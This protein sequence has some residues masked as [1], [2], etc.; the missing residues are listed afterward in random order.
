MKFQKQEKFQ[1]LQELMTYQDLERRHVDGFDARDPQNSWRKS[2]FRKSGEW[3]WFCSQIISERKCCERCGS[4]DVLQ[5]H[6]LD[7]EHYSDLDPSKF[8]LLCSVCHCKI[9]S[10]CGT[11]ERRKQCPKVDR[12]FLTIV[13]YKET[14]K[15]VFAKTGKFLKKSWAQE[16][17]EKKS[18]GSWI[19]VK[20]MSE[21][22]KKSVRAGLEFMADHPELFG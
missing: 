9:E 8:K 12:Q 13:P 17:A 5:V 20:P 21:T 7:P 15:T 2:M 3:K 19:N 6:H 4:T 11:E 18:P 10:F 1:S 22:K 16:M 14:E